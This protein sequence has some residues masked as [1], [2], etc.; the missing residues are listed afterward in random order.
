[1]IRL[2]SLLF[3]GAGLVFAGCLPITEGRILGRDLAMADARFATLP[4]TMTV[5]FAPSPGVQRAYTAADL[6]HMARAN[7]IQAAD[8]SAIC[9]E[10]P[11]HR[12]A[13][14][15]A[16]TAM[17][18]TLP[19]EAELRIV[20]VASL[21]VPAGAVEFPLE[22][23]EPPAPSSHGVQLWR[24]FVR[25]AGTRRMS[26]W[27]RVDVA[28]RMTAVVT[29]RDLPQDATIRAASLRIE[30]TTRPFDRVA[31]ATRIEEVAGRMPK[32]ALKAGSV[33]PLNALADAPT[34]RQGDSVPVVVESGLTRVR[35]DAIAEHAARD[36]DMVELKNPA[37]GKTFRGRLD[38]GPKVTVIIAG[39]QRL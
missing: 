14:A 7:G 16:R 38:P 27:A 39:G 20:E 18:S 17:R 35:F 30:T 6:K 31:A 10:L 37:N 34:V 29:E 25:Y 36:G 9:F 15:D 2:L 23:I 22:G 8:F 5:G 4:A 11:M 33:I 21:D 24:G 3:S 28:V 13:E 32:R 12:F 19:P 1:M 26:V